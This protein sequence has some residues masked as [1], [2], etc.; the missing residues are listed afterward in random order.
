MRG[1]AAE[2]TAKGTKYC[3][4]NS[5]LGHAGETFDW[6]RALACS[7]AQAWKMDAQGFKEQQ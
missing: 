5:Q 1:L 4:T 2:L 3:K 6:L 7:G